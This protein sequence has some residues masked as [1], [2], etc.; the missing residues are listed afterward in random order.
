[1]QRAVITLPLA[2]RVPGDK[3]VIYGEAVAGGGVDETAPVAVVEA[4]PGRRAHPGHLLAGHLT[5]GHLGGWPIRAHLCG[6]HLE[7]EHLREAGRIGWE[8]H[9]RFFGAWTFRVRTRDAAG[10]ESTDYDDVEVTLNT[11]PRRTW[12]TRLLDYDAGS[13]RVQIEI[14]PSADLASL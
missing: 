7:H 8:S 10:N 12:A 1:M 5:L 3:F 2:G 4:F 11:G 9:P 14:V 13:D 6:R